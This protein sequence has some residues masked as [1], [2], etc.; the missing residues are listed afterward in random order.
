M[1]A[2][3]EVALAEYMTEKAYTYYMDSSH[4]LL[5]VLSS[6]ERGVLLLRKDNYRGIDT[7]F[8]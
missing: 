8:K 4:E 7:K 1:T 5:Q 3:Q 2:D 6:K